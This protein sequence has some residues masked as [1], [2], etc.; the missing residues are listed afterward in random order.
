MPDLL[1]IEVTLNSFYSSNPT[2]NLQL[3]K[4]AENIWISFLCSSL[5]TRFV[6][7]QW[8]LS[9][10]LDATLTV[11]WRWSGPIIMKKGHMLMH[12]P[13]I[14]TSIGKWQVSV[15]LPFYWP[16]NSHIII[17]NEQGSII[18]LW[19]QKE[20][21]NIYHK[22]NY[23]RKSLGQWI[24]LGLSSGHGALE[25]RMWKWQSVP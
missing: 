2:P 20:R 8:V 9:G 11:D 16:S 18:L 23:W 4:V 19:A 1:G 5:V 21:I 3:N 12:A 6:T 17:P 24:A 22:P 15:M 25:R 13:T 7:K 10:D 14:N